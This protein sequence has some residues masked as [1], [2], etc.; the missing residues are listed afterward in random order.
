MKEKKLYQQTWFIVLMLL[1][2]A[3][4]GIL[5]MLKYKTWAK[6]IKTTLTILSL[7]IFIPAMIMAFN[8]NSAPSDIADASTDISASALPSPSTLLSPSASPSTS[9]SPTPLTIKEQ[10]TEAAKKGFGQNDFI[11]VEYTEASNYTCITARTGGGMMS[12]YFDIANTLEYLQDLE[13]INIDIFLIT[14]LVDTYG[15]TSDEKVLNAYFEY[16]TRS[17]INW[18]YFIIDNLPD[19]ADTWW[20]HP[21]LA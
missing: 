6:P 21:A 2:L 18:E 13:D 20:V 3:P 4:L 1:V 9:P 19:I 8:T 5:L 17:M 7:I 11:S 10:I 15:N 14:S 16:E 12:I